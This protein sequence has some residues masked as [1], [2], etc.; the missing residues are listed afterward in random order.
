[1]EKYDY[2]IIGAGSAGCVLANRLS[3]N[4]SNKVLLLEA[5]GPDKKLEI[6]IPAAF[7]NLHRTEVDW[8]FSTEPQKNV[9]NRRLYLPRGKTLGGSSSTNAMAYVRGN[10]A[11]YDEWDSLGNKGW[12]YNDVLPYFKKSEHNEDI[13]NNFH[14]KDG[15]LNVTFAKYFRTPYAIAFVEACKEIG[16][17]ENNDYNGDQQEGAGQ[18][19]FTIKNGKRHSTAAAFLKPVLKRANLTVIT[20]A[21][22]KQII[23]EDNKA[24][25]VEYII[26]K[27]NSEKVYAS[28]EI[29]LSAGSFQSPQLLMLSGIGSSE[30]LKTHGIELKKELPGVGKNL[31]DHL[32][33][34]ASSL[35]LQ[36]EGFNH[37]LK[38]V[39]QVVD[40]VKYLVAHKGALTCSLL[41][42]VAFCSVNESK[43]VN[44]QFHFCPIQIGNDYVTDFHDP[45]TFPTNA[46]GYSILPTLL[47]PKSRGYVGLKSANPMDA[48]IIEPNF[49]SEEDDLKILVIGVKKALEILKANSF[50]PY[51]KSIIFPVDQTEQG[52]IDHIKKAVETVYHPVGTCKMGNDS[53]A[54]VNDELQVHGIEGLRVVDASIMPIIVSG[55][56]NAPTIMIAEKA[57]DMILKKHT[58][59]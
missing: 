48:P 51:R 3:H 17:P 39:N 29:I 30:E 57:A 34:G 1:M 22:V 50:N 43:N 7:A 12:S 23:I 16:I 38:P 9:D 55:N 42:A 11:D 5:G 46:D 27:N 56:T 41:E 24:I 10:A 26:G 28:K 21:M 49:L 2:I 32:F 13:D 59:K 15:L 35:S 47:K 54:V 44:L 19:Q 45:T 36:K 8:G 14:G 53:M 40:L 18:L 20:H 6:G 33:I 58:E 31:Q 37:H 52:I 4:P 25:G